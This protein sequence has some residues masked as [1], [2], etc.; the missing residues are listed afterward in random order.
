[1]TLLTLED[2]NEY[3]DF[4]DYDRIVGILLHMLD[5][6]AHFTRLEKFL[7]SSQH[8]NCNYPLGKLMIVSLSS[9]VSMGKILGSARER[10]VNSE[11]DC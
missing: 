3:L 8:H 9:C 4:E 6:L 10:E 2:V 5:D 11:T 7:P 1:M